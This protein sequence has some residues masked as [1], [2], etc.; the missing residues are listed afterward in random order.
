MKLH[1]IVVAL[2]V[3]I[4]ACSTSNTRSSPPRPPVDYMTETNTMACMIE[5]DPTKRTICIARTRYSVS[6][7]APIVDEAQRTFCIEA[8]KVEIRKYNQ[9]KK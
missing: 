7:C 9:M 3:T 8:V 4:S 6:H 2:A 5:Q 1:L